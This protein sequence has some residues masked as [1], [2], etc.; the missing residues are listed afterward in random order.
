MQQNPQIQPV[1]MQPGSQ[2]REDK[3]R[4]VRYQKAAQ[5][6]LPNHGNICN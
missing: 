3:K 4:Q 6:P 5:M 2:K 1:G